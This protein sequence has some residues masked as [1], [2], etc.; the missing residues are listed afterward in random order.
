MRHALLV[1]LISCFAFTSF[2]AE[3]I[4]FIL[5]QGI[6]KNAGTHSQAARTEVEIPKAGKVLDL[7]FQRPGLDPNGIA[8]T[9]SLSPN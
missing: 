7:A 9:P 3:E 1:L 6:G 4:T 5:A 2:A 8:I